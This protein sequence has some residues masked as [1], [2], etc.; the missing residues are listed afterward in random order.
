M[1][2]VPAFAK[3]WGGQDKLGAWW[4]AGSLRLGVHSS[5]DYWKVG[6]GI[7]GAHR[8][9]LPFF[10]QGGS[11]L[12]QSWRLWV[13]FILGDGTHLRGI[14]Y[15]FAVS[16]LSFRPRECSAWLLIT[17]SVNHQPFG[18]CRTRQYPN[19]WCLSVQCPE[20]GEV[21][22]SSWWPSI[23]VQQHHVSGSRERSTLGTLSRTIVKDMSGFLFPELGAFLW[24]VIHRWLCQ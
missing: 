23:Q 10:S 18:F 9:Q 3:P 13:D 14:Y 2:I 19:G 24:M 12:C 15:P 1:F 11:A 8:V 7:K 5:S 6:L 20:V 21:I 4:G 22:Q 16:D 17:A